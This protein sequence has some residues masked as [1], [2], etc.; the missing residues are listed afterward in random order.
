[1]TPPLSVGDSPWFSVIDVTTVRLSSSVSPRPPNPL[2]AFGVRGAVAALAISLA[3]LQPQTTQADTLDF[4]LGKALFDRIWTPAPASTDATDGLGPMFDA[5]SCAACHPGTRKGRGQAPVVLRLGSRDGRPDSALGRQAQ[6]R[7]VPGLSPEVAENLNEWPRGRP[8]AGINLSARLA[9]ALA[10]TGAFDRVSDDAL[11]A[12]AD[13]DDTDGDGLSGRVHWRS[14]PDGSRRAGRY[15]WKALEADL[16]GQ[17]AS[18]LVTDM[19]LSNPRN[20]AHQGDCTAAQ[21][22]CLQAPHGASDRFDDL[23]VGA[24]AFRVLVH[25]VRRLA[26]PP[27]PKDDQGLRAFTALG[28]AGCHR[29][30]LP[31]ETGEPIPAFTDLL[32]HDMGKALD[33]GVGEGDAAPGEWRTAPLLGL[34]RVLAEGRGL[35]HD[36][37]ARTLGEALAFH[38]GEAT[39]AARTYRD[40]PPSLRAQLHRFLEGL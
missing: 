32:L 7:A 29:P 17:V 28:C 5:R 38:G 26:P 21:P 37:R 39:A 18:A 16:A 15:G 2:P 31:S 11:A 8:A 25:Y 36:G 30:T 10:G 35:L 24:E 19:G 22:D 13:P 33:D 1:I 14:L 6:R 20:A 9:P 3:L 27:V 12:L 34:G 4:A 23:E 40:A